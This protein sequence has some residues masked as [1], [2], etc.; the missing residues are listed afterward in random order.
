MSLDTRGSVRRFT[1]AY[2]TNQDPRVKVDGF[3]RTV[4]E[5]NQEL[6]LVGRAIEFL[7]AG[8]K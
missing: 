3:S 2:E 5:A 8:P 4:D 7:D 6:G 1:F